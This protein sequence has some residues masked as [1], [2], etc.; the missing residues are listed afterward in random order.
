MRVGESVVSLDSQQFDPFRN[1]TTSSFDVSR[2][3]CESQRRATVLF[4]VFCLVR[5]ISN[6]F[7]NF[8]GNRM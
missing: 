2:E 3:E 5:L 4:I 1:M 8:I 7:E 6:K